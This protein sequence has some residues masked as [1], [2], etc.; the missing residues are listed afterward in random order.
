MHRHGQPPPQS[1]A[2]PVADVGGEVSS[3]IESQ[4]VRLFNQLARQQLSLSPPRTLSSSFN[5][6]LPLPFAF[7]PSRVFASPLFWSGEGLNFSN[8]GSF[9]ETFAAIE[10][11]DFRA[12][13]PLPLPKHLSRLPLDPSSTSTNI[14]YPKHDTPANC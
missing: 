1:R 2:K 5:Q 13:I 6:T 14:G 8:P 3:P 9:R 12:M 10:D 7:D 4:A 11:V